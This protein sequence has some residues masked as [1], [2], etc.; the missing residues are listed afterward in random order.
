MRI[1]IDLNLGKNWAHTKTR[2]I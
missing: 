1:A 2:Y